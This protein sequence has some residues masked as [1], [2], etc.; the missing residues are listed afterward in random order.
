[1]L[2][3]HTSEGPQCQVNCHNSFDAVLPK[4]P[5]LPC[6]LS[7]KS[8]QSIMY[9]MMDPEGYSLNSLKS[10]LETW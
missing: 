1:M 2:K 3:K 7:G 4:I 5:H 6:A 8:M 10:N 9:P